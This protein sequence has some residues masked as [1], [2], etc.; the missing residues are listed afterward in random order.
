MYAVNPRQLL[1][2]GEEID[3]NNES[4]VNMVFSTNGAGIIGHSYAK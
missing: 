4:I 1:K 2:R 3:I